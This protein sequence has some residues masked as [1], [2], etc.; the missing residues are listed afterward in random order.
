MIR[1]STTK[2]E[3]TIVNLLDILEEVNAGKIQLTDWQRDWVWTDENIKSLL[4]SIS[5]S[6]PIGAI[7]AL[8]TGGSEVVFKARPF[9]G[10]NL[11]E[12]SFDIDIIEKLIID[13][14]QRITTTYQAFYNESVLV[15][16]NRS[17]NF[18]NIRYYIDIEKAIQAIDDDY[19]IDKRDCI[20]S[21]VFT[22]EEQ[23]EMSLFPFNKV[24]DPSDWRIQYKSY[25][26]AVKDGKFS[27]IKVNMFKT[28]EINIIDRIKHHQLSMQTL[29]KNTT[30]EVVDTIYSAVNTKN[31]PLDAFDLLASKYATKQY[32]LRNTWIDFITD[33][34]IQFPNIYTT[35][36]SIERINLLQIICLLV[37]YKKQI[38]NTDSLTYIRNVS[39]MRNDILKLSLQEFESNLELAMFGYVSAA[40]FL[41]N[42]HIYETKYIPYLAQL[43]PLAVLFSILGNRANMPNIKTKITRWY[44]CGIF[45][46]VYGASADRKAMQDIPDMINWINNL[47]EV[48]STISLMHFNSDR[49]ELV[50]SLNNAEYKAIHSLILAEC[51]DFITGDNISDSVYM[52]SHVDIHHIFPRRWCRD[53]NIPETQANSIIN[54]TPISSESNNYISDNAPSNYINNIDASESIMD[55]I[56]ASHYIDKNY[57]R[58]DDFANFYHTRKLALLSLIEQKTGQSII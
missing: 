39:C 24:I 51:K 15:K 54:K 47:A 58:L 53:N 49:L 32:D 22:D 25:W 13:G 20:I 17:K 31:K 28:F 33:L 43:T 3:I 27:T 41:I 16:S 57:I 8:Q 56:L 5:F 14:Q 52:N 10:T 18:Q 46:K 48:P 2:V 40:R 50:S 30:Y 23:F 6:F 1:H 11:D 45:G 35:C 21:G 55:E 42:Q 9:I 7:T 26:D 4:M 19:V 12:E 34:N 36:K 29:H 38:T 37:T 44:W